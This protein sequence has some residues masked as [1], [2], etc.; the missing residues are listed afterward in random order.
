MYTHIYVNQ[1]T[2]IVNETLNIYKS[3]L[4]KYVCLLPVSTKIRR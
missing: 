2:E 3:Y 4:I 1:I